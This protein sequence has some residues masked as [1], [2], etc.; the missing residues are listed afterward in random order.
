MR[1]RQLTSTSTGAFDMTDRGRPSSYKPDHAELARKFCML[2]ATNDDLAACFEVAGSTI[3]YWIATQPEFA[4][5]VRQG[6][7]LADAAVVHKLY[8]RAMGFSIETK[9]YVLYR[10]EQKELPQTLHYPPDVMACMFWLRNRRRRQ[11]N[12]RAAPPAE[13]GLTL[14]ELEAAAERAREPHAE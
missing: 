2:G 9:K 13:S 3:D 8:S 12:E 11:W 7:D 14:S 1:D 4:E 10:G 5:G 6:R